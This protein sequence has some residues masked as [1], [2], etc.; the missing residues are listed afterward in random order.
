[1]GVQIG[2]KTLMSYLNSPKEERPGL[3]L[4]FLNTQNSKGCFDTNFKS[5]DFLDKSFSPL[6]NVSTMKIVFLRGWPVFFT[7]RAYERLHPKRI[8]SY[9]KI[10]PFKMCSKNSIVTNE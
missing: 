1:M 2:L 9:P 7:L 5:F 6:N 4:F 8:T 3:C 10:G